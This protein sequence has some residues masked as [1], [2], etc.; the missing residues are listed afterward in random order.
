MEAIATT[1]Y[2]DNLVFGTGSELLA[3]HSRGVVLTFSFDY[4]DPF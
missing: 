4:F 1:N 3:F 2:F